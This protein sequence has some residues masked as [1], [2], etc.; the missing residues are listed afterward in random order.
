MDSAFTQREGLV[1]LLGYGIF[2]FMLATYYLD[3]SKTKENYLVAD[4]KIGW[5]KS[6]FS[7]AATWIWAPALF[8]ATLKAY[9]QGIA[10]LFW[11]TV[12]NI[13]CLLIF[14]YFAIK[15]REMCPKGFTLSS[16]MRD[17]YSDRVQNLYLI[18]LIGLAVCQFAVQ[19]LAGGAVIAY[20]T[21]LDFFIITLILSATALSY[22]FISGVRASILTDYWQMWFILVVVVVVVPWIVIESGGWSVVMAGIGGKSGEYSNPFNAEVAYS[23]GIVVTIGLLAGPFGD[24]SFWQRTFATKKKEIKKAFICSALIFGIVPIFTGLIGFVAAGLGIEGKPQ[25]IN[26]ITA[27]MLLPT[28]VLVPFAIMLISGLVSTLDSALCSVSSLCGHDISNKKTTITYSDMDWAKIGMV[29]LAIGGLLIA[30]IP[31]MKILYL[32]LFYGTLRASTLIPTVLTI[33]KGKLSEQGMFYGICLA[34]FV[35]APLMAYGNFGGGL[36][37]KVAGAVFTVLSSGIVAWL[38]TIYGKNTKKR[39]SR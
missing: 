39:N 2:M 29:L 34:L 10:G 12:P 27:Q 36:H 9:T 38:W 7:V 14:T 18:E 16:F 26:I 20:L 23:F 35:G 13:A 11:F 3:P 37:Y 6:G 32:F 33:I 21:G 28:W 15:V 24:Q 22:S 19:L 25:L 5:L 4:R 1:I 30:N 8:V 31:D 17:K